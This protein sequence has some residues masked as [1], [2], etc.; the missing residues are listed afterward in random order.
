MLPQLRRVRLSVVECRRIVHHFLHRAVALPRIAPVHWSAPA[1]LT[2]AAKTKTRR[3]WSTQFCTEGH[4]AGTG[5]RYRHSVSARPEDVLVSK[6]RFSCFDKRGC[7]V[8]GFN[9][10]G[11]AAQAECSTRKQALPFVLAGLWR[12]SWESGGRRGDGMLR[13]QVL[14]FPGS[15]WQGAGSNYKCIFT[16]SLTI[17]PV[18]ASMSCLLCVR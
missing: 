6:G 1:S 5:K 18:Y 7:F 2:L 14:R 9:A 3:G 13:P 4:G 17:K 8:S 10:A 12:G 15:S 16:L 11:S